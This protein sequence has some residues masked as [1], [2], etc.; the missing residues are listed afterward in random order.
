MGSKAN[1][2]LMKTKLLIVSLLL[3][4]NSF[5]QK[6]PITGLCWSDVFTATSTSCSPDAWTAANSGYFDA[7]YAVSGDCLDD[8]R[9]Y[10]PPSVVVPTVTTTAITAITG[11]TATSGGNVTADG[12]ASVTVRGV[13][14]NTYT[15]PTTANSHTSD[16]T[17]TGSF[18]SS[19]TPL[20]GGYTYYVR[21]Y[22][23]NSA[24]TSY[25]SNV[26][27][28]T[29]CTRPSGLYNM[30][31][32]SV[33]NGVAVTSSNYC[34]TRYYYPDAGSSTSFNTQYQGGASGNPIYLGLGTDC[35]RVSDGYYVEFAGGQS[36]GLR[37][38]GGNWYNCPPE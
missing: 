32:Y 26:S 2:F 5:G 33:T 12:G 8:W 30:V 37:V 4:L 11:T 3:C 7:A 24:G 28:T 22:A 16:G 38:S 29:D 21:A 25:G 19:L 17:G 20:T 15:N 10:G 23:T 27:F 1:Q 9:N 31:L 14:W 13:C 36:Y 34:T 18:A 35:T 6:L